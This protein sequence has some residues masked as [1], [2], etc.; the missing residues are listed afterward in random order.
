MANLPQLGSREIVPYTCCSE[1]ECGADDLHVAAHLRRLQPKDVR[2]NR[3]GTPRQK[4]QHD[5]ALALYTFQ[6]IQL[7][8]PATEHAE[9]CFYAHS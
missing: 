9:A 7:H 8:S 1:A 3:Q 4:M 2:A 6:T 5:G